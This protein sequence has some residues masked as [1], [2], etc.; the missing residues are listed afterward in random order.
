[1]LSN[2]NLVRKNTNKQ[3]FQQVFYKKIRVP[4]RFTPIYLQKSKKITPNSL[5]SPN[6]LPLLHHEVAIFAEDRLRLGIR[7]Q[8]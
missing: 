6:I 1:M 8:A 4:P 5:Q 2:L 7:L 3:A